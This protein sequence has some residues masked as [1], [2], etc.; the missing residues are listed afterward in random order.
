VQA[1][2]TPP[3][4]DAL[5][6]WLASV[7]AWL[8]GLVF[9]VPAFEK[10]FREVGAT[11]WWGRQAVIATSHVTQHPMGMVLAVAVLGGSIFAYSRWKAHARAGVTLEIGTLLGWLVAVCATVAL[12]SPIDDGSRL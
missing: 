7:V 11:M 4:L 8:A 5:V 1:P 12:F 6:F 3:P 10:M 9:V 2:T